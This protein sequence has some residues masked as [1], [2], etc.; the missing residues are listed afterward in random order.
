ME[1]KNDEKQCLL[2]IF[3]FKMISPNTSAC[4]KISTFSKNAVNNSLSYTI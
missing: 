4:I 2:S 1:K 3:G